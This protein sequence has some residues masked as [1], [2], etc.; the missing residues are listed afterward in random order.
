MNEKTLEKSISVLGTV[1]LAAVFFL[2]W[3]GSGYGC[4]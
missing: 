2:W 4:P 1:V 3:A